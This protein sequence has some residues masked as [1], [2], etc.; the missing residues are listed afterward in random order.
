MKMH[1][2]NMAFRPPPYRFDDDAGSAALLIRAFRLYVMP[3]RWQV[4]LCAGLL[5]A[6]ACAPYLM[7]FYGRIVLDHILVVGE[8]PAA[9]A[10]EESVGLS[11]AAHERS[12]Q[13]APPRPATVG[14]R[15]AHGAH[16]GTRP[17]GAAR[18]LAL[19]FV[20]YFGTI[21]GLNQISRLLQRL[22]V[23]IGQ[24]ITADL[25]EAM[26]TKVLQLS[27]AYHKEHSPGR[28]LARIVSD[29][30]VVQEQMITTILDVSSNV[31]M[32]LV[33]LTILLAVEWR[34]AVIALGVMPL[35]VMLRLRARLSLRDINR[36]IRHTNSCM[37]G[38][39][40]QKLE[41]IKAIQAYHRESHERLT[42]HRLSACMLR[43]SIY[44]QV[45][46][47]GL[48][49]SAGIISSIGTTGIFLFG[50]H[51]VLEGHMTFGQMMFAYGAAVNLF[52]PILV[53]SQLSI[54]VTRLLV[55]LQRL[56]RVLDE[57]V[58]IVDAP[59]AVQFPEP[60]TK[61]ITLQ[62]VHFRYGESLPVVLEDVLMRIR[63]GSWL[64][65]MGASGSGKTT[66]LYLLSR[67]YE[68]QG[69]EILLD[70]VPLSKI[71]MASL[72]ER[73]ALVPQEPQ[74][75]SG[76]VRENIC[77]GFPDAQPSQIMAAAKAAE[78]HDF[79]MQLPIKYETIL[80]ERGTSLSGGQRQRLSLARAL[81]TEPDL[82]LLDDCTSAL[83]AE[84]E[85]RIQQTLI[86]AL[87]GKTAV[88]VSQR[89][90]M[91]QRCQ[92]ICVLGNGLI[93]EYGTH[94]DLVKQRGFYS[95]LV[96]Q[97]TEGGAQ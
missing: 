21:V 40:S 73:V 62:H 31:V 41:G 24:Q 39:V 83:D 71:R 19:L 42:F 48:G 67:L 32:V 49:R 81:L 25:R 52:A 88:I 12:V 76:T 34:M 35:Y 23:R 61:G 82:L 56:V 16:D 69:G 13:T 38:L 9:A 11:A 53:L 91:A 87:E 18:R 92:R 15:F 17:A 51:R 93:S 3:H 66:L 72:R 97:Q 20:V 84:T 79:I 90:S 89:I 10:P 85:R 33:G 7:A 57:P 29:V 95:R 43:D 59:D 47:A 64:C 46:G 26:H 94:E 54:T 60:L 30:G 78:L 74:I 75:F 5:S 44:Q 27:L 68:P 36:N 2:R 45:L 50:V 77:Y 70:N 96:A 1:H 86:Q 8:A 65:V 63:T 80:G 55:T 22:R 6:S 4:L 14:R 58:E 28:L 37:Y